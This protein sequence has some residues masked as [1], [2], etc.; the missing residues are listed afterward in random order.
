MMDRDSI[1]LPVNPAF[2]ETKAQ[3]LAKYQQLHPAG[4]AAASPAS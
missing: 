3:L 2:I 1:L 4:S